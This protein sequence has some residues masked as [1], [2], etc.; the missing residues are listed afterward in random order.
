ML[1]LFSQLI[2]FVWLH[3]TTSVKRICYVMLCYTS[4]TESNPRQLKDCKGDK[5]RSNGPHC[6]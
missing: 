5:L 3:L 2:N 4:L 6:L 1:N